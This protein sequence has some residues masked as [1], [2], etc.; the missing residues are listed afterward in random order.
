[1][2]PISTTCHAPMAARRFG[3]GFMIAYNL[4]SSSTTN[5]RSRSQPQPTYRGNAGGLGRRGA[6]PSSFRDGQ[7]APTRPSRP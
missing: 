1:M 6:Q 3:M 2:M 4:L 5:L 7:G